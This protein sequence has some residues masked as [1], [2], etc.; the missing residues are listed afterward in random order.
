MREIHD[1][2]FE[3][4]FEMLTDGIISVITREDFEKGLG[5]TLEE[6]CERNIESHE[7][8][9]SITRAQV[10]KDIPKFGEL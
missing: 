3:K 5:S 8:I 2:L 4:D 10:K 9:L 6:A 7:R 1:T